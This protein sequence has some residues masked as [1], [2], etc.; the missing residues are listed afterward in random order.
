MRGMIGPDKAGIL[1]DAIYATGYERVYDL[2]RYRLGV[3]A[4]VNRPSRSRDDIAE[5][6]HVIHVFYLD[7]PKTGRFLRAFHK[8]R[9]ILVTSSLDS[10]QI[11]QPGRPYPADALSG[12]FFPRTK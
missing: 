7:R 4:E 10:H 2:R 3:S 11:E 8:L 12:S 6:D 1:I 5:T 9:K